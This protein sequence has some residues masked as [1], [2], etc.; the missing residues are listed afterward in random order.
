VCC[1]IRDHLAAAFP[2]FAAGFGSL[3]DSAPAW[4]LLRHFPSPAARHRAG[5]DGLAAGPRRAGVRFQT[6]TLRAVLAWAGA[7]P[8]PDLAAAGHR[9]VA[10]ALDDDRTRNP[11]DILGLER[12]TAALLVRTPYLLLLSFPGVNVVSAAA[13]AGAMGPTEHD[14]HARRHRP[15]R[16]RPVA[17]P[18]R[19][20]RQGRRPVADAL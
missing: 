12:D 18:E 3:G 13:F 14:A 9:R 19:L 8:A 5:L 2:G 10:P 11:Q 1:Q 16:P 6:P 4:P 7:A 15:R 17:L 20:G